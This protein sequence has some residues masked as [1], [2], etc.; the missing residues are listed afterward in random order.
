MARTAPH[1]FLSYTRL[2]DE[3]HG[4]LITGLRRRLE[5]RVRAIT[6]D[7]DFTIFQDVDGIEFGQHWPSRLDEA[8]AGARF[9]I[10]MLSPLFFRSAACRDEL[11]KFLELEQRAG[12]QDLILPVYLRQ[13]P[14]LERADLRAADP[15]ARAISDRQRRD[16]RR[17]AAL[18]L[19]HPDHDGAIWELAEAV[20]AAVERAGP[21][22]SPATALVA[23]SA[24][25]P[26]AAGDRALAVG[27]VFRDVDEPWCPE[28]VVIPA[29]R[30][31]M[32]SPRD[33]E[34]R[35]PTEGPRHEV[36]IGYR[37]ALGRHAVTFEEY[38]AFCE[39]TGREKPGDKGWG[40]GR[41]P[42]IN[43]S[44]DDATAYCA[45]L[46]AQTGRPYR[47]P[48][49]AEWEYAC[50]AGT[51]TPFW[52]GETITPAQANFGLKR[53]GTVPVDAPGFPAN[54]FGLCHVHG[55]VWEWVA[56]C[57]RYSYEGVPSDGSPRIEDDCQSRVLR[58]GSW[59]GIPWDLR[60]ARREEDAPGSQDHFAGFR[61][62]RM[63]TF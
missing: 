11:A 6:G 60:A 16:W 55:N 31:M 47:L 21:A 54:P 41:R 3:A 33:E 20:A 13:A 25:E 14:V 62:A 8:L 17:Y 52:T 46:T 61:V 34:G 36:R 28:M 27:Q 5:L 48:S 9:L 18:A 51:A 45:W 24:P 39:G 1:A 44:W 23:A 58:G 59:A 49:E 38:D 15:L 12:R 32:G 4:G 63:L 7:R 35:V 37:F 57:W 10:P 50:R 29:G 43:V 42:A 53:N 22:P 26:P 30:F 2:D 19:D 56:D 40:R